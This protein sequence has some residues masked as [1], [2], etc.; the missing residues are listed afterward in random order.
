MSTFSCLSGQKSI[1]EALE[2]CSYNYAIGSMV[3]HL[4]SQVHSLGNF[5]HPAHYRQASTQLIQ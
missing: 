2:E 4:S 1:T 3:E 5:I